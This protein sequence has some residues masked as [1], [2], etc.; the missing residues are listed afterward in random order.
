MMKKRG[1]TLACLAL[2]LFT[3]SAAFAQ[4]APD[5]VESV[6][7]A[8]KVVMAEGRESLVDAADAKPGEV[9]EYVATYRN[10]GKGAV[11]GMQ[12]TMPIPPQTEFIAGSARPAQAKA[13]LDGRSFADIPLKRTVERDG[14]RIEVEVPYREYRYLRWFAAELGG[15]KSAAYTARV[16]VIDDRAPG[17]PGSKGGGK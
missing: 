13:S 6:L 12:A 3:A 15:G 10:S 16:R 17:G 4:K 7:V 9:I 8:R 5:P 14:R 11:T 1:A 2:S